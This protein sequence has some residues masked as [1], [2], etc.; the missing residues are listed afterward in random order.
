MNKDLLYKYFR[1][2]A[3]SSDIDKIVEW[4]QK[5]P[6]N[7]DYFAEQ[8]A[9]WEIAECNS[10]RYHKI[11]PNNQSYIKVLIGCAAVII[12]LLT[13]NIFVDKEGGDLSNPQLSVL[14]ENI[15][16]RVSYTDKGVKAMIILPDGSKVWLNSDTKIVYPEIFSGEAR[17]VSI[18]GEAYFEVVKSEIPMIVKT[19]KDLSIEVLGTSFSIKCYDNDNISTTTLYDGIVKM[20]YKDFKDNITKVIEM[21][22]AES[23]SYYDKGYVEYKNIKSDIDKEVAWKDGILVFDNTPFDEVFKMLERWHGT[24]YEITSKKIYNSKLTASFNTESIVQIMEMIKYCA[25]IDYNIE[26]SKVTIF[27]VI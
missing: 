23:F 26:D 3:S 12:I 16:Q 21:K 19:N 1:G 5:S 11:K 20:H 15:H 6:A 22:P 25:D 24:E 10:L 14:S 17:N 13:L 7:N 8:K 2:Q 27:D 9:L 4:V 18:S